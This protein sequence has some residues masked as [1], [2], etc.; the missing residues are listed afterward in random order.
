MILLTRPQTES[1]ALAQILGAENCV[2]APMME[3]V[4][5]EFEAPKNHQA[6]ISTSGNVEYDAD[7]KIPSQGK[8]AQEILQY[9]LNNLQRNGGKIV[10]L[11]GDDVTLDIAAELVTQGFEAE[12][13]IAY[14]QVA[15]KK[16]DAD[17]KEVSI[18]TFFSLNSLK[19]FRNLCGEQDLG[20]ISCVCIS[21]K[22]AN[23]AEKM[24]WKNLLISQQPNLSGML[25]KIRQAVLD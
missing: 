24:G 23:T 9:C 16:F 17:L 15:T 20:H 2:I 4:K 21:K 6:T 22:L 12:R 5:L 8:T 25:E 13:V 19:N 1:E 14:K 11:S 7:I 18:A 10:Y 3:I